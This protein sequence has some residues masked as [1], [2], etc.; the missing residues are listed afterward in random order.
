MEYRVIL[1]FDPQQSIMDGREG[2]DSINK[3]LASLWA[4]QKKF[5]DEL[6]KITKRKERTFPFY[7]SPCV[8]ALTDENEVIGFIKLEPD[9]KKGFLV[10]A[11]S[12]VD[13]RFRRQGVYKLMMKRVCKM[14]ADFNK[15]GHPDG[16]FDKII[17][18]VDKSNGKSKKTHRAMGFAPCLVWSEITPEALAKKLDFAE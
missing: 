3:I 16:V 11:Y 1:M 15:S 9:T 5:V 2:Q 4:A 6:I 14:A 18:G 13:A 7:A 12:W 10:V 8:C 17:V